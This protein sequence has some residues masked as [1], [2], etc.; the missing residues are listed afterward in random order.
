MYLWLS[1]KPEQI[2]AAFA[3]LSQRRRRRGM[4]GRDE[5]RHPAVPAHDL[6]SPSDAAAHRLTPRPAK[7][8]TSTAS[9]A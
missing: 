3:A 5:T 7:P 2:V 9:K 6:P 1:L 8:A 4:Q